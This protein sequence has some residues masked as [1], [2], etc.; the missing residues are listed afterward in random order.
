MPDSP[1]VPEGIAKNTITVPYNDLG[2]LK[3]AFEKFGNDIAGVIVEPVA[4]IMGVVPP[5]EGF[6]QGL[7]D[8]TTE[9]DALLIL[10]EVIIGLRV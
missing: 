4:G 1:G 9:Y 8:I 2:A 7:R 3:I 6:L 10:D 5:I